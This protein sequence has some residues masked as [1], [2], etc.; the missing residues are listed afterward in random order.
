MLQTIRDKI[1]GW[2]A[3]V[4]LGAIAIVFIFWG[5]ELGSVT[6]SSSYAAKVNGDTVPL[7]T[8]QKAW[9]ERQ[10]QLQQSLKAE[11][12]EELKKQQQAAVMD[13]YI[14][15]RLLAQRVEK[16]G[17]RASD[18]D[19]A[20]TLYGIS[21]LQVDG[22]FSRERYKAA[23]VQ[24]GMSEAQFEQQLRSD[25]ELSQL[26][27]GVVDTAFVTPSELARQQALQGEQRDIDYALLSA[28]Q[29][30]NSVTVKDDEVQAWY[31]ARRQEYST[32]ESVDLQYIELRLEDAA[33][34]VTI[35]DEALRAYYDQIKDR[36][37][38]PERRHARHILIAVG[39]GLDDAAANKQAEDVLAKIKAGG[40]FAALAKQ[41]SKDPGSAAKGG[42]LGWA[43]RGQ[44]VAPFEEA[45][46]GM[47]PGEVRGPIKTQFGYHIIKLDELEAARHKSFDEVRAEVETEYR[48][49][50]A[51]AV[52][53]DKTQQLADNAFAS[54]TELESVAKTF[55]I[56]LQTLKGVTRQGGGE[57]GADSPVIEAAF[58]EPVLE[59]GQNSSLVTIGE[60]RALVLRA[61]DHKS[62]EQRPLDQVRAEITAKLKE[63]AAQAA[64]KKSG[65]EILQRLQGGQL[66]WTALAK[67][68]QA[69]PVGKRT[70]ERQAQDVQPAI[71]SSAFAAPK[72]GSDAMPVYSGVSL[73]NGDYAIVA[74]TGVRAGAMPVD[75]QQIAARSRQAAEI[76]NAEFSG[77][78]SELERNA[79]IT[80]NEKAFE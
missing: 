58:S 39:D 6:G 11:L 30:E 15:A 8:V 70:V 3:M 27:S 42:D 53:Y 73:G 47:S 29:L 20:N 55:G 77:Y 41:Y 80:R 22:K 51:R 48:N 37:E 34:D 31:D 75:T 28:K 5:V 45:V 68:T 69:K 61:T 19:I 43:G 65:E 13:Q 21:A 59:K 78:V 67:E 10:S 63:Q 44:F 4:F 38:S 9:Q 54:L 16:Q 14:R 46:F 56:P 35:N 79:E 62:P 49:D 50:R 7:D 64:A 66:N 40:D 23:L 72:T 12:P 2:F 26:Q 32:P 76:G 1:T 60:E 33:K 25:L 74:V 57:F 71:L 17:L 18:A 52:F 36:Y 24:E